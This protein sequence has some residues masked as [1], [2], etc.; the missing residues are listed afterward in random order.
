MSWNVMDYRK[1]IMGI[2]YGLG[3]ALFFTSLRKKY[4]AR[5]LAGKRD[6]RLLHLPTGHKGIGVFACAKDFVRS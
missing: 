1:I 2:A 4:K 6:V 3:P 5:S